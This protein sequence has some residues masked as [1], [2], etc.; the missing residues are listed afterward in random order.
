MET[1]KHVIYD[2]QSYFSRFLKYEFRKT[3]HFDT[4][5]NFN[6]LENG[7]NNHSVVLYVI[8]SELE[9]VNFMR[10]YKKGIP[11]IVCTFN[12]NL[13]LTMRNIDGI[14]LL[15]TSKVKAEVRVELKSYLNLIHFTLFA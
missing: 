8:Y 5:K 13:L 9:L 3:L 4:F 10:I 6:A 1:K 11:L 7:I 15:D 12:K 2:S 14:L